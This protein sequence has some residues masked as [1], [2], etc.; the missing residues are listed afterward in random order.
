MSPPKRLVLASASPRRRDL[1]ARAGLDFRIEPSEA[2][3]T[4]PAGLS[5]EDA[6]VALARR[7][8]RAVASRANGEV[9]I[10]ADTIV[11]AESGE[12][13]GKPSGPADAR[14]MLETLSA[15][16]HSVTTG[17]VII[18]TRSGRELSRA[19]TTEIVFAA[20]SDEEIDRYIQSGEPMGKAGAYAIQETAD[21]FVREVRGSFSNVVGLPM[22]AVEEMLA[23][24]DS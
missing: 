21:R 4:M 17:V 22:E 13:L 19:V 10:A 16:T 14:R 7:K 3:E 5:P 12:I 2:D 15:S 18:D 8:A 1:L 6:A 20:M 9:V 11:V 23:H 24:I